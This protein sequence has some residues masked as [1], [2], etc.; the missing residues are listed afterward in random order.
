MSCNVHDKFCVR[1]HRQF[2]YAEFQHTTEVT[3]FIT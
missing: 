2:S 1:E 3:D